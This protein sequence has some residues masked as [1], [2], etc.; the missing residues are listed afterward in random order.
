MFRPEQV[1]KAFVMKPLF[2]HQEKLKGLDEKAEFDDRFYQPKGGE[3]TG[4][5]FYQNEDSDDKDFVHD[6]VEE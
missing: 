4:K 3:T 2:V 6:F 1:D 5:A